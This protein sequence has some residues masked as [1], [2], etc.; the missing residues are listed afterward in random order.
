MTVPTIIYADPPETFD[1]MDM[2]R[3]EPGGKGV[4]CIRFDATP[5]ELADLPGVQALI[6]GAIK[7]ASHIMPRYF[8]VY[9]RTGVHI[10]V[11]ED[12]FIA[13]QV[14]SEYPGGRIIETVEVA[15]I[16]ALTPA[17]ILAKWSRSTPHTGEP[18]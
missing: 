17:D 9:S 11:W 7:E 2:W 5:A 16:R 14:L 1:G 12:G 6:A 4:K 18:T 10:G 13:S 3:S 8:A 15:S